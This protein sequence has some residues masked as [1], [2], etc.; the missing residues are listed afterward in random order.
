MRYRV[1][2]VDEN[3]KMI[4]AGESVALGDGPRDLRYIAEC[5]GL[6][7]GDVIYISDRYIRLEENDDLLYLDLTRSD[8]VV[9][10]EPWGPELAQRLY[11][12]AIA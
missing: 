9:G 1:F 2:K 10:G 12:M 8:V 11:R 5:H 6:S 3:G 7:P 4:F